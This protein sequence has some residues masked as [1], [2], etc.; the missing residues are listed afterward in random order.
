[1]RVSAIPQWLVL[2]PQ[3]WHSFGKQTNRAKHLS[4]Q[5]LSLNKYKEMDQQSELLIK[6]LARKMSYYE[7][8]LVNLMTLWEHVVTYESLG[9]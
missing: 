1:M 7:Q 9:V 8:M 2:Q 5:F 4:K 3:L 6:G